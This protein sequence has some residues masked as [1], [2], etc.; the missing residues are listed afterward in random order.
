MNNN[1]HEILKLKGEIHVINEKI[2]ELSHKISSQYD[3]IINTEEDKIKTASKFINSY[4]NKE[5]N[6]S[7]KILGKKVENFINNKNEEINQFKKY[8]QC[9]FDS[10]ESYIKNQ[11]FHDVLD[12]LAKLEDEF[13]QK[14]IDLVKRTSLKK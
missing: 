9:K 5:I 6:K 11:K 2:S 3:R 12:Q 7:T 13:Q 1:D 4:V 10:L 8:M 14:A